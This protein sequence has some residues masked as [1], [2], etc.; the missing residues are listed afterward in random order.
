MSCLKEF[1]DC[2]GI[3]FLFADLNID[4]PHDSNNNVI[5]F[6]QERDFVQIIKDSTHIQGGLIDHI[7]VPRN[8]VSKVRFETKSLFYSDHDALIFSIDP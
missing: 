8:L 7:W 4:F 1:L 3:S 2:N 5:L 6:L